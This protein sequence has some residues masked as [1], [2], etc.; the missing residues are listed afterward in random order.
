MNSIFKLTCRVLFP[1]PWF[2]R[3]NIPWNRNCI[4]CVPEICLVFI[5][6]WSLSH[7]WYRYLY[8]SYLIFVTSSTGSAGVKF[9]RLVS[10]NPELTLETHVTTTTTLP[11]S[12]PPKHLNFTCI[13]ALYLNLCCFVAELVVSRFTLFWLSSFWGH[14]LAGNGGGGKKWQIRG[15]VLVH[16]I[17]ILT[18]EFCKTY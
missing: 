9:F 12:A 16:V 7:A 2:C 17:V 15:M 18:V 11:L 6:P 5:G 4:K 1:G 8:L 13:S 14:F 10:K 3:E